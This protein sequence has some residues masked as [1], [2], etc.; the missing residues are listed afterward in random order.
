LWCDDASLRFWGFPGHHFAVP[1]IHS[2]ALSFIC[3]NDTRSDHP[4]T[5][6]TIFF[7]NLPEVEFEPEPSLSALLPILLVNWGDIAGDTIAS[8]VMHHPS[9]S[10]LADL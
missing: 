9:S 2:H 5:T 1:L 6:T 10:I 7:D 3:G 4:T 8:V